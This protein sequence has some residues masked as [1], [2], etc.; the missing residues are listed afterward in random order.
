MTVWSE[1]FGRYAVERIGFENRLDE[2]LRKADEPLSL[3]KQEGRNR[4]VLSD[5]PDVEAKKE[6]L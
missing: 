3:A 4:A 6:A 5:F 2:A 1:L